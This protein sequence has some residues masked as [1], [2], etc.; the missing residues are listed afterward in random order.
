MSKI[1]MRAIPLKSIVNG[2]LEY[3]AMLTAI[4]QRP[5]NPQGGTT[6][7]EI[8]EVS[9]VLKKLEDCADGDDL[10]LTESEWAM[11]KR[12]MSSH[13]WAQNVPELETFYDDVE[14]AEERELS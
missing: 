5:E 12:R 9:P 3:K 8:R 1:K 6:I 10:L 4:F 13:P 11:A 7:K 2:Q 14:G